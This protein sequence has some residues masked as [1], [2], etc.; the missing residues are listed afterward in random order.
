MTDLA[1][2]IKREVEDI[3]MRAGFSGYLVKA[4]SKPMPGSHTAG[5]IIVIVIPIREEPPCAASPSR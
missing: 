2:Y 3:L 5:K 4:E 1:P